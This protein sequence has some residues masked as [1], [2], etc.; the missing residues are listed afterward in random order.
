MTKPLSKVDIQFE[1][2]YSPEKARRLVMEVNRVVTKV[3]E[4]IVSVGSAAAPTTTV[5]SHV[6]ATTAALG[7][8]HTVSGLTS[9]M[10]LKADSETNAKFA[11]LKFSEMDQT[12]QA[13]FETASQGDVLLFWD[14]FFSMRP[15]T[16]I[17]G[18]SDPMAD[19]ILGWDAATDGF[20]WRSAGTGITLAP[21]AISVDVDAVVAAVLAV[22]PPKLYSRFL[23]MGA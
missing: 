15:S 6:F 14:G 2:I 19:V 4:V 7:P 23:M 22:L 21:G 18:V 10:V 9:G 16:D 17:L 3:N 13:T 8:E 5:S 12:D 1:M 20:V 11:K